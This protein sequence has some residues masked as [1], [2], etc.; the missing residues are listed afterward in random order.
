MKQLFDFHH[1]YLAARMVPEETQERFQDRLEILTAP[2]F[3]IAHEQRSGG[4]QI[5]ALARFAPVSEIASDKLL[6]SFDFAGEYVSNLVEGRN[7]DFAFGL[8]R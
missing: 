4:A 6:V 7:R 3:R 2:Q 1:A 8:S 5:A